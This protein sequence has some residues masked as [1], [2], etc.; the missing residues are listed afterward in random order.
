MEIR[1]TSASFSFFVCLL[2]NSE[3]LLPAQTLTLRDGFTSRAVVINYLG[4][5]F[6]VLNVD[7]FF[8]W[9]CG[10][11]CCDN[12]SQPVTAHPCRWRVCAAR[13]PDPLCGLIGGQ[14]WLLSGVMRNPMD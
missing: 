12:L 11:L 7:S 3:L 13:K 10:L 9:I 5:T 14:W 1:L 2:I 6:E 8:K 4:S